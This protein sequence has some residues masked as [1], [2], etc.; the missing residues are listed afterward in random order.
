VLR[1][2][3]FNSLGG[4]SKGTVAGEGGRLRF[5]E[6]YAD[7]ERQAEIRSFLEIVDADHYNAVS[8]RLVGE[9]WEPFMTIAFVRHGAQPVSLDGEWSESW[10]M[11]FNT[12]RDDNYE[13]YR[14]DLRSGEEMNLTAAPTTEWAYAG[15]DQLL[16]LSNREAGGRS[17]FRIYRLDAAGGELVP[18][19]G[20][21]VVDSWIGVLPDGGGYVVCAAESGDRELFLLD[22]SGARVRQLT[23]NEADDCQPDVTPDGETIVFW[24]DRGGSAELWSMPLGGGEARQLTHFPTNDSAPGHNYGGEG[25]PRISPDGRRIVWP[26]MRN[27]TDFDIYSMAIDG[28]DV[29]RL[30]EHLGDDGYPSW[31]PDGEWIAF[32]SDRF[33]SIDLFVMR[34]DGSELTRITD[35]EGSEQAPVWVPRLAEDPSE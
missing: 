30:T 2:W 15:G 5:D 10:D 8:E 33:G 35:D 27:G 4:V 19:G 26:S 24:S 28:S 6:S 13:V 31:S 17:G 23:D 11:V 16:L 18:L 9:E 12:N 29:R 14:R 20:P 1:F 3:Y 34:A 32:D 25:P 22:G 7:D 21:R